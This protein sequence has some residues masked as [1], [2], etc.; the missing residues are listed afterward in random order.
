MENKKVRVA[1]LGFWHSHASTNPDIQFTGLGVYGTVKAHQDIEVAAGWDWD[2]ERGEKECSRLGIPYVKDLNE[3]LG[4]ED[5]DGVVIMGET[6]QHKEFC[7]KAAQY[8]KHIY[9]NKVLA[10]TIKEA[11]EIVHEVKKNNVVMITMLSRLYEKWCIKIRDLIREGAVG[12][13]AAIRIWHAHGIVTRYYPTDGMGFLPDDHGFLLKEDGAG[14]CYVDM[15]HPQYMTPFFLEGMPESVYS[16]MSSVTGRGNVEDNAI[17]ILDYKDGPYV[18]I[19]EGWACGPVTTEVE[20]QGTEGTILYRDDR[21]DERYSY[22]AIR[23]GEN[24][25]FEDL[26]V[27]QADDTPLDEWIRCIRNKVLPEEN[28]KRAL[29]LSRLNEAAYK[30]ANLKKPVFIKSLEEV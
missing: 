7:C 5:I 15:C 22:F 27:E 9:V 14:G 29:D 6:V 17:A 3:L 26:P 23:R 1:F 28:M 13:V 16:R 2:Q 30:S 20:V 10:P 21:S 24:S 12:K 19:E 4:R 25:K 18:T 8:G 11:N